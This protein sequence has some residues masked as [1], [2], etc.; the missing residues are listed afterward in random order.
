[1]TLTSQVQQNANQLH[2]VATDAAQTA[3]LKETQAASAVDKLEENLSHKTNAAAAE[4][5]ADVQSAKA[6]ASGYV[7][8]AK[9]LASSAIATAQVCLN[10][11]LL[12]THWTCLISCIVVHP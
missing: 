6:T 7:E 10:F 12:S 9:N 2:K 5:A 1:M 4:G 11:S 3:E 8:Q